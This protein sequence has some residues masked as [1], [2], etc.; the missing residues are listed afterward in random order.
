MRLCATLYVTLNF[1][2]C[3]FSQPPDPIL[4]YNGVQQVWK[5]NDRWFEKYTGYE[6]VEYKIDL[7]ADT[8]YR[9]GSNSKLITTI[10]LF[11]LCK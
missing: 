9:V 10:A 1:V 2:N 6:S 8:R 7:T 5:G 4:S 11:Q 3:V